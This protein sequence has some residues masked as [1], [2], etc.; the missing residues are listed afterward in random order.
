MMT[1]RLLR[2]LLVIALC[3]CPSVCAAESEDGEPDGVKSATPDQTVGKV[4]ADPAGA[5]AKSSLTV[6]PGTSTEQSEKADTK[7]NPVPGLAP[8]VITNTGISVPITKEK[9]GGAVGSGISDSGPAPPQDSELTSPVPITKGEPGNTG[10]QEAQSSNNPST[11]QTNMKADGS[12]K[13]SAATT[14]NTTTTTTTTTTTAPEAPST[15]TTE[16]PTTKTTRAPS[17]L[18]EIDGSLSS[19]AWV[20]APLLLAVSALAYTAVG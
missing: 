10:T 4:V 6:S 18:P 8:P 17:R 5:S 1:C 9:E 13:T 15:K 7:G 3:F 20:C 16:A 11:N 12:T 19:S 14:I 2:T